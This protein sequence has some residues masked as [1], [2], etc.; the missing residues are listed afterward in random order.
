MKI[1][2]ASCCSLCGALV[3]MAGASMSPGALAA[4]AVAEMGPAELRSLFRTP[5][6]IVA[7]GL[8]DYNEDY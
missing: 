3:W 4:S 1:T 8:G 7:D 2:R 6:L 5:G